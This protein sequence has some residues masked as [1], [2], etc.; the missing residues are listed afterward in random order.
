MEWDP[1][2]IQ[3]GEVTFCELLNDHPTGPLSFPASQ[4]SH[5]SVDKEMT[6]TKEI[7]TDP[8]VNR[9]IRDLR[10][11]LFS[12]IKTTDARIPTELELVE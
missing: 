9:I 12:S 8:W 5:F 6:W 10:Q 1:N 11:E 7:I 3:S 4:L 2:L